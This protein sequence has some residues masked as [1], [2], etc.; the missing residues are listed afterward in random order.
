MNTDDDLITCARIAFGVRLLQVTNSKT[1][2]GK[3]AQAL[4]LWNGKGN[5]TIKSRQLNRLLDKTAKIYGEQGEVL[6][7]DRLVNAKTGKA[8]KGFDD[9]LAQI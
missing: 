4:G 2:Y 6:E 5:F 9:Y 7:F 1:T 3:F 8:G